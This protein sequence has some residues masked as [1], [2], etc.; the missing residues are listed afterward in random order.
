MTASWSPAAIAALDRDV[1]GARARGAPHAEGLD[2]LIAIAADRECRAVEVLRR[3]G[4]NPD[5]LL[6]APHRP[7][8]QQSTG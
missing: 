2:L 3:T 1:A 4:V 7:P 6:A 8:C 5:A